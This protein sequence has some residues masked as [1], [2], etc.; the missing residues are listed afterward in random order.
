MADQRKAAQREPFAIVYLTELP[1][2]AQLTR[3]ELLVY[4]WAVGRIRANP[5]GSW[6]A[7]ATQIQAATGLRSVRQVRRCLSRLRQLGVLVNLAPVN[8]TARW[9]IRD[10]PARGDILVRGDEN[11]TPRVTSSSPR[12]DENVTPR[13][14]GMSPINET[15][16]P[17][18]NLETATQEIEEFWDA[19]AEK[20]R[21]QHSRLMDVEI[22]Q[23]SAHRWPEAAIVMGWRPSAAALAAAGRRPVADWWREARERC[24]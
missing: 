2:L 7:A 1:N 5:S 4:L 16:N 19:L 24:A 21:D 15:S 8:R 20:E 22:L 13:V 3:D 11:V 10:M 12:G 17:Q 6:S 18:I 14:T 23:A 9:A